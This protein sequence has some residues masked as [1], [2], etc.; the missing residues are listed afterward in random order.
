MKNYLTRLNP[1]T[2]PH[3]PQV[4][5]SQNASDNTFVR[6]GAL[7]N[8]VVSMATVVALHTS[9]PARSA[10]VSDFEQSDDGWTVA[11]DGDLTWVSSGGNPGGFLRVDD[12]NAGGHNWIYAPPKFLGNWRS[13]VNQTLAV[14]SRAI[15]GTPDSPPNMHVVITGPGGSATVAMARAM[16]FSWQSFSVSIDPATWT[17]SAGSWGNLIT[18]ITEL[19]IEAEYYT[20]EDSVGF[21][22]I[23]LGSSFGLRQVTERAGG[24]PCPTCCQIIHR[25]PILSPSGDQFVFASTWNVDDAADNPNPTRNTEIFR[26][27]IPPDVFHQFTATDAGISVP[28]DFTD[29][30]VAVLSSSPELPGNADANGDLFAYPWTTVGNIQALTDTLG[31][32]WENPPPPPVDPFTSWATEVL[33]FSSEYSAGSWSASRVLGEPDVY[34]QAGDN[35]NAWASATADGQREFLVL[36]YEEPRPINTVI[37]YE[38]DHP[39]A[40]DR[41]AVRSADDGTWATVWTAEAV[42]TSEGARALEAAFS[43]TAYPVDAVRIEINSPA[44]AGWNEIDAVAIRAGGCPAA[45]FGE[46]DWPTMANLHA[47]LSSDGG[48]CVWASNRNIPTVGNPEGANADENYEIYLQDL[49]TGA[50]R[51]LT[52]TLDGDAETPAAG[53]N[54][55]PRVSTDGSRVVFVSNRDLDEGSLPSGRHGL[56]WIE[57]QDAPK[58]LTSAELVVEREFP[59]FGMDD[60]GRRV[61]FASE[62]DLTGGNA[63]GNAEIFTVA[64]PSGRVTQ[65]TDT[66]GDSVNSRPI[67][68]GDGLK[69]AFLSN[70]DL[71]GS[72]QN[73][74]GSV[75]LW[76]S[77]DENQN[78]LD[79]FVQVTNLP[80]TPGATEDRTHWMDWYSMDRDGSHL[81][82]CTNADL[83]GQNSAHDYEIFLTTFDWGPAGL[84]ITRIN[85]TAEGQ[86]ELQWDASM[87]GL[88]FTV[89]WS[90]NLLPASWEPVPPADQ[91]PLDST[92]WTSKAPAS[93]DQRYYRVRA[94]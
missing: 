6:R 36:G 12:Q 86:V 62:G 53:A 14:E 26:Y 51:Q 64:L 34:P 28:F 45:W 82:M 83:T 69:I 2:K 17:V 42:A 58:R 56:F 48:S 55:W 35:A 70:A 88:R 5:P 84:R 29:S 50:T 18:N 71:G 21:D 24:G 41:V 72:G 79:P 90:G 27:D 46:E 47:D 10:V 31:P 74:D 67:L 11:P 91:W 39:G 65:I 77:H 78:D 3:A 32:P 92:T 13:F 30:T 93:E 52:R 68:S 63:D 61:V 20:G 25:Q 37:I 73:L 33:D 94:D 75:E 23:R 66:T 19:R 60:A 81:V 7:L 8:I 43:L 9:Q 15:V 87:P 89:E 49:N 57:G 4:R 44:V 85:R 38:T 80:G 40:V 59:A 54:L 1:I 76:V 22:N 16:T